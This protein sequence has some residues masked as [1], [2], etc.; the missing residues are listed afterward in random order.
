MSSVTKRALF[1]L[2]TEDAVL[3]GMLGRDSH[4][5]A[6][7]RPAIYGQPRA[8]N[9]NDLPQ[10]TVRRTGDLPDPNPEL[11]GHIW[12]ETYE[13]MAWAKTSDNK[14]TDIQD[15]VK[16]LLHEKRLILEGGANHKYTIKVGGSPEEF[17]GENEEA[18]S[19]GIYQLVFSS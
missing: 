17:D 9:E 1:K 16:Y 3:N 6:N 10:L 5:R 2:F 14:H 11:S 4:P 18:V 7:G 13:V 19:I 8:N 15:R 12:H